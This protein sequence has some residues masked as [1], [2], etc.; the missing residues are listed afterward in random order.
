MS[1]LG[2]IGHG[3]MTLQWTPMHVYSLVIPVRM[4]SLD[5]SLN[6]IKNSQSILEMRNEAHADQALSDK[7]ENN[8][9]SSESSQNSGQ[10]EW[11]DLYL[12]GFLTARTSQPAGLAMCKSSRHHRHRDCS[13][14]KRKDQSASPEDFDSD[15]PD[16]LGGYHKGPVNIEQYELRNADRSPWRAGH[17]TYKE[18][19]HQAH[20]THENGCAQASMPRTIHKAKNTNTLFSKDDGLLRRLKEE[21][22]L[23]CGNGLR[24]TFLGGQGNLFNLIQH[25]AQVLWFKVVM[26]V[27]A[28]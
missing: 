4:R 2:Y 5:T 10:C 26:H 21:D 27:K 23:P 25:E 20:N 12:N 18:S 6:D 1:K 3:K 13:K 28:M 19:P 9:A 15:D 11:G 17:P 16:D 7:H 8:M 14:Q 22:Q 24:S